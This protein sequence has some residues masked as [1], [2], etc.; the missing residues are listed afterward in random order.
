MHKAT[1]TVVNGNVTKMEDVLA[2]ITAVV[3]HEPLYR[4]LET[5]GKYGWKPEGDVPKVF[6]TGQTY[7]ITVTKP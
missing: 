1:L 3:P 5:I 2:K 6:N 7:T 4:T